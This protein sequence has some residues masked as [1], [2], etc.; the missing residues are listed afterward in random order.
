MILVCYVIISLEILLIVRCFT[1]VLLWKEVTSPM[2]G[3]NYGVFNCSY[4]NSCLTRPDFT[5]KRLNENTYST[6]NRCSL[7]KNL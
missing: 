1:S 4:N 7:S 3:E 6:M 5:T 2:N